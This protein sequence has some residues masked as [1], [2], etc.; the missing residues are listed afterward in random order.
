MGLLSS[1]GRDLRFAIRQLRQTPIVS[2][3]ALLSLALGIGANVAIFSLVNA[4][5]LKALPVHEP[6]RL[7]VLAYEGTRGPNTSFTNPQWEYLRDHQ[8]IFINALA[9]GGARFN[10]NAGGEARP[11]A[12][13]FVSGRY[14]E[15][16]GVTPLIG[17]LL[18]PDDDQRGGGTEGPV[19]VLGY[20]LWQ[21]EYGGDPS[22]IG[23]SI[24]IDGHPFTV[25]GVAPRDFFGVQVGRAFDVMVPIGTEPIIRGVESSLDR[26]SNWWITLAARL[27]PGQSAAQA[28][29]RLRAFQP[30]LREATMPQDVHSLSS[31]ASSDSC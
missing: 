21:R 22:V 30:Q 24:A 19:A 25:V 2:G 18:T 13:N 27:A 29:A 31:S 4:L 5:M 23:R 20:G 16:L 9:Y 15:T 3:V 6:D 28:Q 11:V 17:R 10:L 12:G 14:F 8:D 1:L 26:R 7:V